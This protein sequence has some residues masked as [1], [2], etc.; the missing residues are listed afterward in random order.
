MLVF[1]KA[2]LFSQSDFYLHNAIVKSSI[3]DWQVRLL[4]LIFDENERQK[5]FKK[6]RE[7]DKY[8]CFIKKGNRF[9]VCF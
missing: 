1:L 3:S 4:L 7:I 6:K 9:Y 5:F 2:L 8:V